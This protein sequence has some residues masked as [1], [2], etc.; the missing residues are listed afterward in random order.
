MHDEVRGLNEPMN[1]ELHLPHDSQ[2][3]ALYLAYFKIQQ[4]AG[5]AGVARREETTSKQCVTVFISRQIHKMKSHH[6]QHPTDLLPTTDKSPGLVRSQTKPIDKA[7]M[8][9]IFAARRRRAQ[10]EMA[11]KEAVV[12]DD[13]NAVVVA[14]DKA[15]DEAGENGGGNAAVAANLNGNATSNNDSNGQIKTETAVKK[16]TSNSR[17]ALEMYG[18]YKLDK[19]VVNSCSGGEKS[20]KSHHERS[21]GEEEIRVVNNGGKKENAKED[22][23]HKEGINNEEKSS[24]SNQGKEKT[25]RFVNNP[26]CSPPR[27]R[28]VTT[29]H[30][31]DEE[32]D[33]DFLLFV[34]G[35]KR[36]VV[37]DHTEVSLLLL[38][39]FLL[40]GYR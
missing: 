21:S 38:L 6:Q 40:L 15:N 10:I 23:I 19:R 27:P 4:A 20:V 25:V 35:L 13:W 29:L 5:T 33:D 14:V 8:K 24:S 7:E 9:R 26:Q 39:L 37:G 30:E 12:N 17:R 22:I 16:S 11:N 34:A 32:E 2:L 36:E 31:V 3:N 28:T 1:H 18:R